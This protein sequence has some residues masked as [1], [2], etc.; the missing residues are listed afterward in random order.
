[1]EDLTSMTTPP[2]YGPGYESSPWPVPTP[3]TPAPPDRTGLRRRTAALLLAGALGAGALGAGIT[4]AADGRGAGVGTPALG[5]TQVSAASAP[6]AGAGTAQS[7]AAVIG[8]SVVTIKEVG[9]QQGRQIAGTGSGIVLSKDG[10][11][12]TNNHVVAAAAAGGRATVTFQDGTTVPATIVGTDPTSDLAVV[13]VA[14]SDKLVPATFDSGT[15]TVGQPVLAV[16]APLGLSNTVTEGIVSTI[17]RAVRTGENADSQSVIDAVQTDAAIN[18]GNSGGA[19]VDLSGKVVGINSA[20]ATSGGSTG[21]VGVG[22]AI[23]AA[24]VTRVADQIVK[25]GHAT[26]PLLGVSVGNTQDGSGA[27][28]QQVT[29]AAQAAGLQDGDVVTSVGG[30]AVTDADTL[31]VAV[32]DHAPGDQVTLT[33]LRGGQSQ[34]GTATLET[35]PT[36]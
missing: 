20:I 17:G 16:G 9:V 22:F 2:P 27:V 3:Q 7:A 15:L 26:H 31:I 36:T 10:F 19:L 8:P 25:T 23:P 1:M 13:K 12:V 11:I 30:R 32:R 14:T 29:G 4:L 5:V 28:V 24:D 34:T 33:Y 35:A 18:P 21:N 6:A